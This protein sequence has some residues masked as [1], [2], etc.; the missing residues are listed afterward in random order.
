MKTWAHA[1]DFVAEKCHLGKNSKY[2]VEEEEMCNCQEKKT[3]VII[4]V[5]LH[6]YCIQSP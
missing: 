1:P 5:D 2:E 4:Q 3:E 6:A